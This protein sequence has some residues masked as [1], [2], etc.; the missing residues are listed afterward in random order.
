MRW[1]AGALRRVCACEAQG[2][3]QGQR[4]APSRR[5]GGRGG[6][7]GWLLGAL[8]LLDAAGGAREAAAIAGALA[9][10]RLR[11][12]AS[13]AAG[14]CGAWACALCCS[15]FCRGDSTCRECLRWMPLWQAVHCGR[16]HSHAGQ[17][18][19]WECQPV[20][21][22]SQCW[23]VQLGKLQGLWGARGLVCCRR[24]GSAAGGRL[25]ADRHQRR[26][27]AVGA[28]GARPRAGRQRRDRGRAGCAAGLGAA[29]GPRGGVGGS[30]AVGAAPGAPPGGGAPGGRPAVRVPVRRCPSGPDGVPVGWVRCDLHSRAVQQLVLVVQWH[31]EARLFGQRGRCWMAA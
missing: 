13:Q 23:A 20:A 10:G 2:L 26:G 27:A 1:L 4:P 6:S 24:A 21:S 28:G 5:L 15:A 9:G 11:A 31:V 12:A 8:A 22:G 17:G 30:P 18:R 3:G 16:V 7:D 25:A 29:G 14:A 19:M